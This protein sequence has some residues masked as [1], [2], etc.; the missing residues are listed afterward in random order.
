MKKKTVKT[1]G[2]SLT[3]VKTPFRFKVR[4]FKNM[5]FLRLILFI[6]KIT[7]KHHTPL[8]MFIVKYFLYNNQR[9]IPI[10]FYT[11]N[12]VFWQEYT[13]YQGDY[14]DRALARIQILREN[15]HN[16]WIE[17][18]RNIMTD[19]MWKQYFKERNKDNK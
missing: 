4:W 5:F 14:V 11:T 13:D 19:E 18:K 7:K 9:Y 2:L 1:D 8:E 16:R 10:R 17:G 12:S 3:Y 15:K 6:R